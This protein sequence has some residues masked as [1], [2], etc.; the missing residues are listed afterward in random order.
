MAIKN[1]TAIQAK[2]A[3]STSGRKRKEEDHDSDTYL[4][5]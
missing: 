2:T 3:G 5:R 4:I 1:F